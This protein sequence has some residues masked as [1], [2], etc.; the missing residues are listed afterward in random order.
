MGDNAVV[1]DRF[2]LRS[3]RIWWVPATLLVAWVVIAAT[4]VP[5]WL[6]WPYAIGNLI[7]TAIA[8]RLQVARLEE[9]GD[10][11]QDLRP[12]LRLLCVGQ[13]PSGWATIVLS[14]F[15]IA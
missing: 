8:L 1:W 3:G 9:W 6:G 7:G 12:L 4:P 15:A 14:V 10:E 5:A 11:R 13:V 2:D